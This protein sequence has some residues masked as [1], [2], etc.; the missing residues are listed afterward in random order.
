MRY[1][2]IRRSTILCPC[3]Q[4]GRSSVGDGTSSCDGHQRNFEFL[5]LLTRERRHP[6]VDIPIYA[7]TCNC[8]IVSLEPDS[9]RFEAPTRP[10]DEPQTK[11]PSIRQLTQAIHNG[12]ARKKMPKLETHCGAMYCGIKLDLSSGGKSLVFRFSTML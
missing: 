9:G 10:F 6:H 3:I 8:G 2:R 11:T 4:T 12:A 5:T 1:A 7:I